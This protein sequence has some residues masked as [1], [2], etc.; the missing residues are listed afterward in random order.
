[1]SYQFIKEK[2]DKNLKNKNYI[3]FI[4]S[5]NDSK[6]DIEKYLRLCD[7]FIP[8][9]MLTVND[10]KEIIAKQWIKH[11]GIVQSSAINYTYD[12][13]FKEIIN[14]L[15]LLDHHHMCNLW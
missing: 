10:L 3:T 15:I 6:G 8:K 7:G 2:L 14:L 13:D 12:G 1:M 11:F 5:A 4:R 9:A